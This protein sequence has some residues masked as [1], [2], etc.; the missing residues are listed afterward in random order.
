MK[1]KFLPFIEKK[2]ETVYLV[3][4]VRISAKS[5]L[6]NTF[7]GSHLRRALSAYYFERNK[8]AHGFID[9]LVCAMMNSNHAA[10]LALENGMVQIKGK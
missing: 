3:N 1:N 9:K 10:C 4:G 8:L 6:A 7:V 2:S 5:K